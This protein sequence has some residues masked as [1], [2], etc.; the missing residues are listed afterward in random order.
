MNWRRILAYGVLL[1][2]AQ[3]TIGIADGFF[4]PRQSGLFP[5]LG[6]VSFFAC[7]AIF[8]HLAYRQ[9]IR[10]LAHGSLALIAYC[11]ASLALG[12]ALS[13]L[14]GSIP[15]LRLALEWLSLVVA[16]LAGVAMGSVFRRNVS[17]AI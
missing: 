11:A 12:D 10:P 14:L 8:A 1:F 9:K 16:M 17:S 2:V 4:F 3:W 5:G 13:N 7:M 6:L 15:V